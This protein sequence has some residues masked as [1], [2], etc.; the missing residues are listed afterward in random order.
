[1]LLGIL[2]TIHILVCIALVGVILLQQSEG[3]ALGMGG[4]G[5]GGGILSSRGTG[6]LLTRTSW[7]LGITFFVLSL[8]L[9]LIAGHDRASSS[10]VDRVKIDGIDLNAPKPLTPAPAPVAPASDAGALLAPTPQVRA[11]A[12]P[13]TQAQTPQAPQTPAAKTSAA[14]APA[15]PANVPAPKPESKTP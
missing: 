2:L 11:V 7:G 15:K 8:V 13:A 5:A 14:P 6:D 10:V 3:G 12:R 1:M 4:G 9:T